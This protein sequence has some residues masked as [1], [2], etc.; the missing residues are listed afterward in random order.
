MIV[1]LMMTRLTDGH[2]TDNHDA[3]TDHETNH[4]ESLY[5]CEA[6]DYE[7]DRATN[8]RGILDRE[9]GGHEADDYEHVIKTQ[10]DQ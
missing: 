4:L 8:N 3:N 1:K 6:T 7:A 2:E 5:N 9:D 10:D